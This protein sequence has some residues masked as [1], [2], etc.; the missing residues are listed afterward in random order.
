MHISEI[1]NLKTNYFCE[2]GMVATVLNIGPIA[3]K[4]LTGKENVK[5]LPIMDK[6]CGLH[7]V[8]RQ[9]E[10]FSVHGNGANTP[11]E[12]QPIYSNLD[13]TIKNKTGG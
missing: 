4:E 1:E 7:V 6:I 13:N 11:L 8:C 12:E 2:T 9:S 3:Y 5:Y 10:S